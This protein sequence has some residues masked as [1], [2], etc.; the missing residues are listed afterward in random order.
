VSIDRGHKED[1]ASWFKCTVRDVS[2]GELFKRV[3]LK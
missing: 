3:F 1:P 2:F